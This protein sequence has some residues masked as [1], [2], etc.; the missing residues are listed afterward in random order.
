MQINIRL[1]SNLRKLAERY[2][3]RHGY[4]NIQ[5]LAKEALREKIM[6]DKTF[7]DREIKLIEG[8]VEKSLSKR[9]L[10]SRKELERALE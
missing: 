4:K 7:T 8:I 10:V 9:K 3:K 6:E 2:A 1:P 5:A